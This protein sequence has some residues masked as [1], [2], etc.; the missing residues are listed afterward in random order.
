MRDDESTRAAPPSSPPD[1]SFVP[2]HSRD[3]EY[4]PSPVLGQVGPLHSTSNP[5]SESPPRLA[6]ILPTSVSQ[7][8]SSSTDVTSSHR[9]ASPAIPAAEPSR[10]RQEDS[11]RVNFPSI[12]RYD[13]VIYEDE[14]PEFSP[15]N[16]SENPSPQLPSQ[17]SESNTPQ[18]VIASRNLHAR[19]KPIDFQFIA[20]MAALRRQTHGTS[21]T[22]STSST[23]H[24]S[25][26][27]LGSPVSIS[28]SAFD[29]S[30]SVV[31]SPVSMVEFP[32]TPVFNDEIPSEQFLQRARIGSSSVEQAPN[33]QNSYSLHDNS[34]ANPSNIPHTATSSIAAS[35]TNTNANPMTNTTTKNT[36]TS[37]LPPPQPPEPTSYIYKARHGFWNQ[38]GDHL[39]PTGYIV[40][41][42]PHLAFPPDLRMY[43][44]EDQGYLDHNGIYTP[45]RAWPELL[46]SLPVKG[47]NPELPYEKFVVWVYR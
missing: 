16:E 30:Y 41:S 13:E 24:A 5:R 25:V 10:A 46:E 35:N 33:L 38:R 7:H 27:L 29:E 34:D 9:P 3:N 37:H 6:S 31:S 40:Y 19:K 28:P 26:A 18:W 17:D 2:L 44:T 32:P 36:T 11:R 23:P 45:A 39:T 15:P 47:R 14:L 12:D 21:S 1:P 22:S 8:A 4:P 42:P 20:S 43:P